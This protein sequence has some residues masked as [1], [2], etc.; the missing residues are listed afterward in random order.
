MAVRT[1]QDAARVLA[2]T[3]G[4]RCF[5]CHDGCIVKNLYQLAECL[6]HMGED[7]YCHHVTGVKN[8]FT[9]WVHDVLGD[10]KLANDLS[11]CTSRAEAARTVRD[12]VVWLQ[13]KLK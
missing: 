2:D 4:D 8:D 6:G 13:K 7:S 10:D 5:F 11:R 1:R 3:S 12:R 9:N